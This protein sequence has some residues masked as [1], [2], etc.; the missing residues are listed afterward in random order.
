MRCAEA[1]DLMTR[2]APGPEPP[3]PPN[4]PNPILAAHVADCPA[5]AR[6]AA[7]LAAARAVFARE[8]AVAP[9]VGFARRVVARLPS[10][11]QVL[12]WAALRT[13]PAGIILAAAL[14]CLGLLQSPTSFGPLLSNDPRPEV[15]LTYAA[16]H[17]QEVREA[18]VPEAVADAESTW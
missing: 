16:F 15:L 4:P 17:P 6:Y 9:S 14:G 12:G 8:S 10:S 11:T 3:N 7:R 1:R 5:C 2:R 18:Q 13:L